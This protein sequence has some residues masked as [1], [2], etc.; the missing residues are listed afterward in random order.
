MKKSKLIIVL[1]MSFC[2]LSC[3]GKNGKD[4]QILDGM[5]KNVYEGV[6]TNSGNY[7]YVVSELNL[8]S[9]VTT[10]YQ[11]NLMGNNWT[12]LGAP[13]TTLTIPYTSIDYIDKKVI[14]Y[15]VAANS[16]YKIVVINNGKNI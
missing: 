16:K 7:S 5:T 9:E 11:E 10:L 15:H 6:M 3:K 1:M 12:E 2:L 13:E 4:G 8:Y 14:Y